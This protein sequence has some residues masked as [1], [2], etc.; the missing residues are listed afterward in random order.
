MADTPEAA[1]EYEMYAADVLV[2]LSEQDVAGLERELRRIE[3]DFMGVVGLVAPQS[4]HRE[5]AER[6]IA[7]AWSSAW[8]WAGRPL[9]A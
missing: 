4:S 6:I 9:P 7:L 2:F 8:L 5:A 3:R 1:D